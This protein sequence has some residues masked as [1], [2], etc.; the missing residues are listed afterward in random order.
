M[1][2]YKYEMEMDLEVP[3]KIK[4][5]FNIQPKEKR[6]MTYPGC[7]AHVDDVGF[8]LVFSQIKTPL[9]A[10]EGGGYEREDVEYLIECGAMHDTILQTH[11]TDEWQEVC[12]EYADE[13]DVSRQIDRHEKRT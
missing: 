12:F 10:K 9:V 8:V 2:E 1:N 3:M 6:T 4:V 11:T 13:I 7:P 5:K